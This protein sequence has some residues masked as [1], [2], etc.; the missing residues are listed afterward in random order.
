MM[1][2]NI[3]EKRDP[4]QAPN[5]R[6]AGREGRLRIAR[7]MMRAGHMRQAIHSLNSLLAGYPGDPDAREAA[8]ELVTTAQ[9]CERRGFIYTALDIYR[10]LESLP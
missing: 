3:Q 6:E 1:S 8:A 2:E 10:Q 7:A 9:D 5:P 4:A